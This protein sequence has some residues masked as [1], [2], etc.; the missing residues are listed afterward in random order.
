MITFILFLLIGS[1]LDM[2]NGW[3]LGL[4]IIYAILWSVGNTIKVIGKI[5]E[6]Q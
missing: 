4:L 5:I 3:Y 2:L 1:K 6:K